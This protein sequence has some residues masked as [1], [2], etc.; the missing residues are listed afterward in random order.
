MRTLH[1]TILSTLILS[2]L[3]L[4]LP[5]LAQSAELP[6][7]IVERGPGGKKVIRFKKPIILVGKRHAP[8]AV[9]VIQRQRQ[10][11]DWGELHGSFVGGIPAAVRKAPF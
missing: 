5:T 11:Y 7:A 8:N 9:Y 6:Q 4:L 3:G 1:A 10:A 2:T